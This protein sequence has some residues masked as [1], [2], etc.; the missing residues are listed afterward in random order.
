MGLGC[1]GHSAPIS[2]LRLQ[3][4]LPCK[5]F[6]LPL[7]PMQRDYSR[8]DSHLCGTSA[9]PVP[10]RAES[11]AIPASTFHSLLP[12][13]D[14]IF[15]IIFF[16]PSFLITDFAARRGRKRSV[17]V[18]ATRHEALMV[19]GQGD[20]PAKA[21]WRGGEMQAKQHGDANRHKEVWCH[22]VTLLPP[23]RGCGCSRRSR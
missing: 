23:Q 1:S 10:H 17:A 4:H 13:I 8:W 15:L 16:L 18:K 6:L 3:M 12:P 2:R 14:S 19:L 21:A 11:D 20:L 9:L 5:S 22:K 7:G